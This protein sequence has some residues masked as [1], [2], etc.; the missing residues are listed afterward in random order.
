LS[1]IRHIPF[2]KSVL[3]YS[4]TAFGGPQGHLGMMHKT[5][6]EKRRDVTDSELM[7]FMA[8]CQMLP[9]PS[10]TQTIALIGYKRGGIVLALL[11]LIIWVLPA[12]ILMAGLSFLIQYIDA[13][14]IQ[15]NIFKFIQPMAVGFLAY[16]A[17]KAMRNSV[18]HPATVI[19]MIVALLATVQFR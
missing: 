2:L 1:T 15:T 14:A 7:D 10:S 8:F 11:T 13:K 3:T 4:L 5:F 17:F 9:G 16:A 6:V 12:A 19:I 18:K